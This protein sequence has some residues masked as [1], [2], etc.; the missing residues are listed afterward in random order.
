MK[1]TIK[2]ILAIVVVFAMLFGL[3]SLE[4]ERNSAKANQII[5]QDTIKVKKQEAKSYK[6]ASEKR[7]I[8]QKSYNE[9]LEEQ[10]KSIK[11]DTIKQK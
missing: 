1:K 9:K 10:I 4:R 3:M 8:E 6:E 11:K 5:Q 7:H 2:D